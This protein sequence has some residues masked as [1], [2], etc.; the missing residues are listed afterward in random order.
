VEKDTGIHHIATMASK[1]A[2][3][4]LVGYGK[5]GIPQ[6]LYQNTHS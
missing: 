2:N 6:K 3:L 1:F 5:C 4:N